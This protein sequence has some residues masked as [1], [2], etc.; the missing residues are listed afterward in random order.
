[1][2]SGLTHNGQLS[3]ED[4]GLTCAF[5]GKKLSN[6]SIQQIKITEIFKK[7]KGEFLNYAKNASPGTQARQ[8][9]MKYKIEKTS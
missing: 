1:M 4:E 6:I 3:N 7:K 8:H 2:C 5:G 9:K